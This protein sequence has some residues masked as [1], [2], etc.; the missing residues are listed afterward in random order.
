MT[1]K[2]RNVMLLL[3]AMLG[4]VWLWP[5]P[6]F[7]HAGL[8]RSEPPDLCTAL[9]SPRVL[10]PA[11]SCNQGGL[12]TAPPTS[13]H[14]WFSEPVQ[15]VRH[16][17]TVIAPSGQRVELGTIQNDGSELS[18]AVNAAEEGTY[19]VNWQIISEDTHPVVGH[20]AFSVGH[21]SAV[22]QASDFAPQ[23]GAVSPPGLV[24]QV[25]GRWL[26]FLGYALAFGPLVFNGLVLRPL[27]PEQL[28]IAQAKTWRLCG[29]GILILL[30][31][32]PLA[33]LG[34]TGS[35]GPAQLFDVDTAGDILSSSFGRVLAQRVGA[36]VLL[37]VLLGGIRQGS[38]WANKVALALGLG[39]AIIDGQASHAVS[40][41]SL[42]AGLVVNTIH[43]VAMGIWIG[44]LLALL[45][46]WPL[47]ALANHRPAF[48]R[49]VWPIGC[50]LFALAY[51]DRQHHVVAASERDRRFIQH[52]LRQN[53]LD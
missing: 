48:T 12:L 36:A 3:G 41:G 7:A 45:T 18:I 50:R 23:I 40:S 29:F 53:C 33:L 10:P 24:L 42:V 31:S 13:V 34:Q 47:P 16:G 8:V 6:V 44:G 39:L 5:R 25:A 11:S 43:L 38:A 27:L 30:I 19:Q 52:R 9:A 49:A 2:W 35:L 28:E 14:L 17:L 26:H 37:W 51:Y 4:L 32:E 46:L 15:T 22:A 20:F 21:T 1:R